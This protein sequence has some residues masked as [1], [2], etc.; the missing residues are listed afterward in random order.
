MKFFHLND[1]IVSSMHPTACN[2]RQKT[3]LF[4]ALNLNHENVK[5]QFLCASVSSNL[6][7]EQNGASSS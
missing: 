3:F 7:A 4:H 5:Q 6:E 2:N 1:A